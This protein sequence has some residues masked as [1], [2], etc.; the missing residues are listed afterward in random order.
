M[1]L[2]HQTHFVFLPFLWLDCPYVT[3]WPSGL[4]F[5]VRSLSSLSAFIPVHLPLSAVKKRAIAAKFLPPHHHPPN[6][7][8]IP[9]KKSI[10]SF[11]AFTN[12]SIYNR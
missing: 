2:V 7:P 8:I 4:G 6:Y 9:P 5:G 10:V 3:R 12:T 11:N 1:Q